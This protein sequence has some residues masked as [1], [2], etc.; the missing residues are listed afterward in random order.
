MIR[1]G[2]RGEARKNL[3]RAID[4]NLPFRTSG[5]MRGD[6]GQPP[7]TGQLNDDERA[8]LN[9]DRDRIVYHVM[10]YATPIYWVLDDGTH[11]RV[12]QRFS[13]TTTRHAGFLPRNV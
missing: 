3:N 4:N 13:V 11:Y 2:I 9:R 6:S 5:A 8:R 10:S 12:E 1:A 7:T